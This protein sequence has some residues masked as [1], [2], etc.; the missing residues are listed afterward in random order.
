M[1]IAEIKADIVT[2]NNNKKDIKY[3]I[4]TNTFNYIT[5]SV[6]RMIFLH[7]YIYISGYYVS[8]FFL[9]LK[10]TIFHTNAEL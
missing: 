10:L 8:L 6:L 1:T 3:P 4:I 5:E 2:S 9:F 7:F